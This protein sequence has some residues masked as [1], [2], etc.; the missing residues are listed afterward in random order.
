MSSCLNEKKVLVNMLLVPPS[1]FRAA[2][3]YATG[4]RIIEISL[5]KTNAYCSYNSSKSVVIN[6]LVDIEALELVQCFVHCERPRN[7]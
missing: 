4:M 5:K 2:P 1:S 6:K 7:E 3:E